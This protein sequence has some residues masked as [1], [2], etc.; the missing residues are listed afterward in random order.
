MSAARIIPMPPRPP[1]AVVV[2]PRPPIAAVP[3]LPLLT[4]CAD[5]AK[6][7]AAAGFPPLAIRP[8]D[9]RPL[10]AGWQTT[11]LNDTVSLILATPGANVGISVP[12][13]LVVLDVDTKSFGPATLAAYEIEHS[14]L[15]DTLRART[16]SDGSHYWFKLPRGASIPNAVAF[17]PGLDVRAPG[18]GYVVAAPS[19]ID[20]KPYRWE[21][22]G[23]DPAPVPEWLLAAMQS[24]KPTADKSCPDGEP[25][26]IP[27]GQRNPTLFEAAA[28]MR[29]SSFT[30][31]MIRIAISSMNAESCAVPLPDSEVAVI[32]ASACKYEPTAAPWQVFAGP[33]VLPPGASLAKPAGVDPASL[34]VGRSRYAE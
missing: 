16:Q 34:G 21:N 6:R 18:K 3:P 22:W 2:P 26:R 27:E 19:N 33:V 8:N 28:G 13:G 7:Y 25:F 5:W 20:G 9:K 23:T 29:R 15:P 1:V 14:P 12:D 4:T 11:T 10:A 17:A 31:T 24:K 30:E 32:V